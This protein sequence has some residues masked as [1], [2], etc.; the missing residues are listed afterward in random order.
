MKFVC[1]FF[2][3]LVESFHICTVL[4]FNFVQSFTV[5]KRSAIG[6]WLTK[7]DESITDK[8]IKITNA[9]ALSRYTL[10][11]ITLANRINLLKK[12]IGNRKKKR[13]NLQ[14][15]N[16]FAL[17]LSIDR[18]TEERSKS[19]LAPVYKSSFFFLIFHLLS[20]FNVIIHKLSSNRDAL[21]SS[22]FVL[23][24]EIIHFQWW[25]SDSQLNS[26]QPNV[27]MNLSSFLSMYQKTTAA[28][29]ICNWTKT[30]CYH[31]P[32][33]TFNVFKNVRCDRLDKRITNYI[34]FLFTWMTI[35]VLL[36]F[37]FC[38]LCSRLF[39]LLPLVVG[40]FFLLFEFTTL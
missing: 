2:S 12:Q 32:L 15:F 27:C 14:L 40:Y 23:A 17:I 24:N 30:N 13:E 37:S 4:N 25:S 18:K 34:F 6:C 28:R 3:I 35:Y 7:R 36:L 5:T 21:F 8:R 20:A 29:K 31:L 10:R 22:F 11:L 9:H 1:F 26:I 19:Q 39:S 16:F 38:L 33:Y